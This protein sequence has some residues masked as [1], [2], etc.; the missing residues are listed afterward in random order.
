MGEKLGYSLGDCSANFV[1]Q[2]MIMF[3]LG[4]YTD[5][6]GIKATA[7]GTILLLARFFDA[8]VDPFVG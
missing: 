1:F 6:F 8:V 4:F 7:A 3:Q 2:I 5:V